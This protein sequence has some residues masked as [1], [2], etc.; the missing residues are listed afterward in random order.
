MAVNKKPTKKAKPKADKK[1]DKRE[2]VFCDEY[3]IHLSPQRAAIAA[4]Y[5]ASTA[6][7]L[8]YLWISETKNP[9]Y[10]KPHLYNA[11][12]EA[13]KKR[14][15]RTEVTQDRVVTEFAKLA[16][17]DPRKFFD[18]GGNLIPIADLDA[19][20]A[21]TLTGMDVTV[22]IRKGAKGEDDEEREY[23][24]KIKYNDKKGALDSL[25]RHL[26]M[27]NDKLGIGGIDSDGE[28][29]EIPI[30]FVAAPKREGSE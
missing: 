1:L 2:K 25:A 10:F 21:A 20:V 28:I 22:L 30:V 19:D 8:A 7:T 3:L 26:G 23:V 11:I 18:K 15:V 24:K 13:M 12:K 5:S 9:K 4:G 6:K 16:F 14:S 27:F 17:L 29:T